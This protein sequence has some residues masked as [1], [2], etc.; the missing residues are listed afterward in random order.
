[1]PLGPTVSFFLSSS[2]FHSVLTAFREWGADTYVGGSFTIAGNVTVHT[3]LAKYSNE[4][5]EEVDSPNSIDQMYGYQSLL[6]YSYS[7]SYTSELSIVGIDT[8]T[9]NDV[10]ETMPTFVSG[11]RPPSAFYAYSNYIFIGGSFEVRLPDGTL[12][13]CCKF[14]SFLFPLQCNLPTDISSSDHL[15]QTES[16]LVWHW[17]YS[18]SKHWQRGCIERK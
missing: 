12:A 2:C 13:D 5:W 15:R 3:G 6:F 17:H 18:L 11:S 7:H 14:F 1:M 9:G 4:V 8:L 10:F 16:H